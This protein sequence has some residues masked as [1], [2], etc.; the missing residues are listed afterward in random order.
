[1]VWNSF[2]TDSQQAIVSGITTITGANGDQIHAYVARPEGP[3]P[4]PGVLLMHHLP[5]WDELY[6]EFT[7]RF[8]QHGYTAITP[9]LYCRDGHG[10]PDEVA[11][12]V[13]A[14]GGADDNQVVADADAAISWLRGLPTSN[15]KV[16]VIGTCSGGRHALLVASKLKTVDACVDLWGGRVVMAPEALTPKLPVAPIDL[17]ADL[18]CPL[19][20]LFGNDDASPT[21]A[22]VDQH[23]AELKK[24]GKN[25]EF[26]RYDGAGHAFWYHDRG[27][28]RPQQ[29]M[30]AWEKTFEF[31]GRYLS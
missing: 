8:A 9:D 25:Y 2:R 26:H 15:G 16:G 6:M 1:M 24:H 29:A 18:S 10:T 4:F 14:G 12:T 21:P 30:D 3:G 5:G 7:R 19:L 13:R 27:A 23:E 11:A 28:F 20:G 22:E 31:F 17:T